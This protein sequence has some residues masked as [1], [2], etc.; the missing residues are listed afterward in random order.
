VSPR[1]RAAASESGVDPAQVAGSG[2]KGR[3]IE[4]DVREAASAGPRLTPAAAAKAGAAG[5]AVPSAGTG[6]GG[7]VRLADLATAAAAG[8]VGPAGSAGEYTEVK[9]SKIRS[10]IAERMMSSLEQAAQLTMNSW[11]DAT[12]ILA[13][14]K[15]VKAQAKEFGLSD[16]NITDM[17]AYALV[18]VLQKHPE[19]NATVE[20]DMVHQYRRVHLALAVDTTRGLM[21]PVVRCADALSLSDLAAALKSVAGQC[22]DGSVNPDLLSGGTLTLS[23]IGTYGIE[24][25]TPIINRPQVAIL[26]LNTI[27][28]KPVAAENGEYR[29][30]PHI[31]LS[32][33]IDHRAVDG[34]PAARF[35][36]ELVQA[37]SSFDLT[38]AA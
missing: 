16:I 15:R 29:M 38:L 4:R 22:Q 32:L 13:Y 11:A 7:R 8:A 35:L 2:P 12:T 17:V 24:S 27:S 9:L 20:G 3:V 31:G 33:T 19:L 23:N 28:P 6:I 10:I 36:K 21:V 34:A 14:R 25:F 5:L 26:G 18:R 37:I 30:V 1:A